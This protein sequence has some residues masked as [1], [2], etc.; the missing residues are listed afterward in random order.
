M[1]TNNYNTFQSNFKFNIKERQEQIKKVLITSIRLKMKLENQLNNLKSNIL[2]D[3]DI[4]IQH[5]KIK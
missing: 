5:L 1:K 4:I 2:I 3:E